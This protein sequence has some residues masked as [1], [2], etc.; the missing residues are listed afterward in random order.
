MGVNAIAAMIGERPTCSNISLIGKKWAT[1]SAPMH[2][3]K[4]KVIK[5]SIGLGIRGCCGG[6]R[7][8][9]V[10]DTRNVRLPFSAITGIFLL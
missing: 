2:A 9:L 8:N 10:L 5:G 7:F 6:I 1:V 3:P 4:Q